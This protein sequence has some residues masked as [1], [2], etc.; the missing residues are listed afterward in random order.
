MIFLSE[1]GSMSFLLILFRNGSSGMT[2]HY[3][4]G[5]RRT[6]VLLFL[7]ASRKPLYIQISAL[8]SKD[9]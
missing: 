5:L 1:K 2:P 9:I 8:R 7:I 4:S 3:R 6:P